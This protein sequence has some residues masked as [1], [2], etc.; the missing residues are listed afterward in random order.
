MERRASG[1]S[2]SNSNYPG[3]F[4]GGNYSPYSLVVNVIYLSVLGFCSFMDHLSVIDMQELILAL[5]SVVEDLINF[6]CRFEFLMEFYVLQLNL[7]FMWE[8]VSHLCSKI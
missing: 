4:T 1:S 3:G 5:V 6:K 8:N 7:I 2:A